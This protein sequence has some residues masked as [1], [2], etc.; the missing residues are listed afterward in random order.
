M[1]IGIHAHTSPSCSDQLNKTTISTT[2]TSLLSFMASTPGTT[3]YKDPL[4]WYRSSLT[5]KISCFSNR[6]KSS[7]EDR[8][9]GCWILLTI[10]SNSFVCL[11]VNSVPL[12]PFPDDL[13][14]SLRS[15][16]TTKE[17]PSF[18]FLVCSFH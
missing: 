1:W 18:P 12:I 14:L 7:I 3:T 13:I 2:E 15:M 5:T 10:T 17:S 4:S 8:P 11:E 16:V 6:H 9:N